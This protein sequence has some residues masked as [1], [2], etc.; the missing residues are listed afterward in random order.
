MTPL[1]V[2]PVG[3]T[4]LALIAVGVGLLLTQ[5]ETQAG[6][7]TLQR[8]R[9]GGPVRIG[10]ANEAPYGYLDSASGQVTGEAPEVARVVLER[11]GA[12]RVDAVVADF[13][14]LIPGL[15]AGRFDVI[16][17]GM[18]ITPERCRQIAFSNPTYR[19]GEALL[20]RAGNPFAL[21]SFE[22]VARH[23][24]ARLGVVGG[25]VEHGY[26]R[27]LAVPESRTV[28]FDSNAEAIAG[29]R[30]DRIDAV[31]VTSLTANDLLGKLGD[32]GV[33]R[34]EPFRDPVIDGKPVRGFGAFGFRPE[35]R[36]LTQAVNAVLKHYIGTR[37]HLQ[38]VQPFGFSKHTLPGNTTA[39][40]LCQGG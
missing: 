18:Y 10:Y 11:L 31:A 12:G 16:A 28:V 40:A 34:A 20:V 8:I 14:A 32:A 23:P 24:R 15:V 2:T 26:A 35:D 30:A 9:E 39:E 33:E 29:L 3:V 25:T 6:P 36:D 7:S 13:G 27:K 19:I 21:H 4:L 5:R 1:R 22:T 38:T 17:A 37:S